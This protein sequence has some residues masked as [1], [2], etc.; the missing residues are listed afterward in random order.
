MTTV[1]KIS[2]KNYDLRQ[3][4]ALF[5][6]YGLEPYRADQI[7][8][9][10]YKKNV[11]SFSEMKNLPAEVVNKLE[12]RYELS[13]FINAKELVSSDQTR[14]YLFKL[15]D[16]N[17]IET[18]LI[19]TPERITVCVSTQVG[20]K[21]HC[22]ICASGLKGFARNLS[23]AE[24]IEQLLCARPKSGLGKITNIVF[25]GMGEPLE[26]YDEVIKAIRIINDEQ[27]FNIGARHITIS[28]AGLIPGI[29]KVADFELQVNLSISLHATSSRQ[30]DNLMPINKKY[31]LPEL[32]E[33]AQEY[34]LKTGRIVTLEYALL[35]EINDTREDATRLAEIAHLIKAKVNLLPF[36]SFPPLK[37][38]SSSPVKVKLFKSWLRNKK[39]PVTVRQ[40]KGAD[41]FAACGQ[42]AGSH[43]L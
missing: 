37:F 5:T 12:E 34:F 29:K 9:W 4:K 43:A 11:G 1:S 10:I 27:G 38:Y 13:E 19:P 24:I 15:K 21:F 40:S 8:H 25:M 35:S 22:A 18:V 33:T 16:G 30:R 32:I 42:L 41:I 7:F 26:N 36:N 3:L 39:T 2:L 20:C 31:P 28:T 17:Q 6:Q 23:A 14:K